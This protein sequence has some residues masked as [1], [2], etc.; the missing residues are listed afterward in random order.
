MDIIWDEKKCQWLKQERQL[1][2]ETFAELI[3]LR[4]Y[5]N[6]MENPSN[7]KQMIFIIPYRGYTY[8][9]PFVIDANKNI[10]LKTIYP[11]RKFH[12]L[13]GGNQYEK[14]TA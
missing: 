1:S 14:D 3:R 5:S 8:G 12:K 10:V 2:F 11:S 7:P 6:R 13:Y 9:V 4:L